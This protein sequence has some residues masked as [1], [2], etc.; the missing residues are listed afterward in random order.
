MAADNTPSIVLFDDILSL[1]PK[2]HTFG[3]LED[4]SEFMSRVTEF[5]EY[6]IFQNSVD[7][8]DV[9]FLTGEDVLLIDGSTPSITHF[10]GS[11]AKT[12]VHSGNH[13]FILQDSSVEINQIEGQ[14]SI[15]LDSFEDLSFL[16]ISSAILTRK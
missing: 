5:Y 13:D 14:V 1:E 2:T 6:P 11:D 4:I 8:S 12:K 9:Q 16:M 7:E 3:D 15:F 10:Y